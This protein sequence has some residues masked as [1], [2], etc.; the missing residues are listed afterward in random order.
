MSRMKTYCGRALS[1]VCC[2]GAST[3]YV[4]SGMRLEEP[5]FSG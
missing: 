4:G 1:G 5:S 3:L 2:N